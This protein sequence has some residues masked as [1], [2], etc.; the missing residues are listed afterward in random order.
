M[1][2]GYTF[3]TDLRTA[4]NFAAMCKCCIRDHRPIVEQAEAQILLLVPTDTLGPFRIKGM[5]MKIG[6]S[7]VPRA[8]LE[9]LHESI[10][11]AGTKHQDLHLASHTLRSL[12]TTAPTI[13]RQ[14]SA[15]VNLSFTI[16]LDFA[17]VSNNS[18][19]R[20]YHGCLA[21]NQTHTVLKYSNR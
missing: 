14:H 15:Q 18:P 17:I 8:F 12:R 20:Q 11:V 3:Q 2:S 7:G 5:R 1:F 10:G 16:G 13:P 4:R 9:Q 6:A 21:L 19:F